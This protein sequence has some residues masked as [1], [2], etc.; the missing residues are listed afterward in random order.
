MKKNG[1]EYRAPGEP[2][3]TAAAADEP[4]RDRVPPSAV[5]LSTVP[6]PTVS[7]SGVNQAAFDRPLLLTPS[8]DLAGYASRHV[9]QGLLL[10]ITTVSVLAVMLIFVFVAREAL[11]FF[12]SQGVGQFVGGADW[13]PTL[14][15]PQEPSYGILTMLVGSLYV[16]LGATVIAVPVALSVAVFLSDIAPFRLRQV[17]KPTLELL[18]A[19]PSVAYGFFAVLVVVPWMQNHAGMDNGANALTASLILAVMAIPTIAS[20]AEDALASAGRELRE[21][22]YALGATR[23]ETIFKVIIPAAHSGII[24]AVILGIMR[25]IGE[26]MVVW[27]ASG[28]S[29]QIPHP[30]WDLTQSVKTIT[31]TIAQDMGESSGEHRQALFAMALV[32]LII[33]LSLN[34]LSEHLLARAR[35]QSRR[36]GMSRRRQRRSGIADALMAHVR[37]V[38]EE[39]GTCMAQ[40][41][42]PLRRSLDKAFTGLAGLM[43]LVMFLALVVI[44]GP[45]LWKGGS[46]VVFRGTVEFRNYQHQAFGRGN[47]PQIEAELASCRRARRNACDILDRFSAGIDPQLLIK[48]V[49]SLDRD[50]RRQLENRVENGEL[51]NSRMKEMLGVSK[52]IRNDLMAAFETTD[53]A[54]AASL[55]DGVLKQADDPAMKGTLAERYFVIARDYGPVAA[56]VD[57]DKRQQYARS[58]AQV[59]SKIEEMFGPGPGRPARSELQADQYGA[60]RWDQALL[61]QK[62]ILWADNYVAPGPG[63]LAV[64]QP[65]PRRNDFAGTEMIVL[66]DMIEHDLDKMLQPQMT[67]YWQ[68]FIDDSKP[69]HLLGGIG[70]EIWGT[71]LLAVLT[72]AFAIPVS[73]ISAA[74]L[75]ECGSDNIVVRI[76]RTFINTL[77]GVPSIVFG[78]FGLVF[79]MLV[80]LPM[81]GMRTRGSIMAGSLT[82]ALL[83]LPMLIRASEEAIRAVPTSYREAALA[84]GAGRLRTFLT[85]TL[86]A[87]LPGIL[88]GVILSLSRAAGETAPILFCAGA[89]VTTGFATSLAD[90]TRTLSYGSWTIAVNESGADKVPHN[91]YGMVMTLVVLVLLL[92]LAAILVRSKLSKRLRG[93]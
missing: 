21:G 88:T 26:T 49:K 2:G 85:V 13:H 48:E 27:M 19:I 17:I 80:L 78:L 53:R 71:L 25:A 36:I 75:V 14:K 4:G 69:G 15:P 32:L 23:A 91:Q 8:Q 37:W 83:V 77:A 38:K 64:N 92:N 6:R 87:S 60:T 29:P 65:Y 76:I 1:Q 62:E 20:V 73:I 12:E 24:A 43:V 55:L 70:P 51:A 67:C 30:W 66:F 72:M 35:R 59:R 39:A 50:F 86:P 33:T 52:A 81:F 34:L 90:E 7:R 89:A 18:A 93:G 68:F 31:A 74:Y 54:A 10:L 82:L 44:L 79:F 11:P 61:L 45:M 63:Q 84:L 16:T 28:N 40:L 57:P 41:L 5:S 58:L 3:T 56:A 22:S 42:R 46:A 9:G 47:G